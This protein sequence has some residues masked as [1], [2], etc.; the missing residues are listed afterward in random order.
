MP[1]VERGNVYREKLNGIKTVGTIGSDSWRLGLVSVAT[2][3]AV[4]HDAGLWVMH[5]ISDHGSIMIIES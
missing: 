4:H 3:Y 1:M 2:E 5:I